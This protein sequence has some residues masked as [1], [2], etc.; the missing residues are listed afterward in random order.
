LGHEVAIAAFH[1]LA[2]SP[3]MWTDGIL[4]YPGSIEDPFARDILPGHAAHFGADIV[5]TLMDAWVLDPPRLVPPH[6]PPSAKVVHWMPVD[7]EPLSQMDARVLVEGKGTPVAMSEFGRRQLER[8]GFGPVRVVPHG[9]D[10][11]LFAPL[12][13]REKAREQ[14]GWA[15]RFVIGINAANQ[16]PVR[17]GFAEQL[18][19]FAEFARDAPE[20][21]LLIHSREQTSQGVGLNRLIDVLGLQGKVIIGDQ[22]QIA[23]GLVSDQDIA[24]F[25]GMIDLLSNCSYGEGFGIPVIESQACGTPVVVTDFSAMAEICGSGW[26]VSGTRW[27]NKGHGAH[28]AAPSVP[29]ILG[30]YREAYALWQSGEIETYREKARAFALAY[31]ADRVLEE[32]W[33]PALDQLA[34]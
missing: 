8:A 27:W 17:K 24:R 21:L 1:G 9:I 15:G 30:A 25:C 20:A 3:L 31:D 23:A 12:M 29:A 34:A 19:S 13:D 11:S 22:Y 2:G 16:D 28:W 6:M 14:A 7:C 18:Q 4:V 5:L 10:T 26:V 32:F 33:R